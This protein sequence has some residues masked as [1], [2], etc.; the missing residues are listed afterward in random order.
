[1]EQQPSTLSNDNYESSNLEEEEVEKNDR[2]KTEAE[3][4]NKGDGKEITLTRPNINGHRPSLAMD[5]DPQRSLSFRTRS[6]LLRNV[7]N[8][9]SRESINISIPQQEDVAMDTR[10]AEQQEEHKIPL[11]ASMGDLPRTSAGPPSPLQRRYSKPRLSLDDIGAH[12]N[13]QGLTIATT[14]NDSLTWRQRRSFRNS[15]RSSISSY[16][17][18][19]SY[20]TGAEFSS[21]STSSP[22]P[23]SVSRSRSRV[24]V[25]EV[26]LIR[27]SLETQKRSKLASALSSMNR[28]K[29]E[30]LGLI[31]RR[32]ETNILLQCLQ[33][34]SRSDTSALNG[35][36]LSG[37]TDRSSSSAEPSAPP[38]RELVLLSGESG[39]GKTA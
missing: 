10:H 1:M 21:A 23:A 24:I 2:N 28:L 5:D 15:V 17:T 39:A 13:I 9:S 3:K 34:V 6:L 19:G 7:E 14:R 35:D 18:L 27:S 37:H 11:S 22:S 33:R 32:E 36:D 8:N 20:Y 29:F 26:T 25:P 30:S 31:G 38:Q 16:N 12:S 4:A